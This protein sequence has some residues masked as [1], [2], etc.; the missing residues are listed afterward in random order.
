MQRD[1]DGHGREIERYPTI[2][3]MRQGALPAL[4]FHSEDKPFGMSQEDWEAIQWAED[5]A[6]CK[7]AHRTEWDWLRGDKHSDHY[8]G[9]DNG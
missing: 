1:D 7:E 4:P 2:H 8:P 5:Q 3:K 6:E 9:A